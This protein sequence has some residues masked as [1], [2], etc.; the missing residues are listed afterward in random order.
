M[1]LISSLFMT[2]LFVSLCSSVAIAG[3]QGTT[4]SVENTASST[5]TQTDTYSW[6]VQKTLKPNQVPYIIREGQ[7]LNVDYLLTA[8]RSSPST[9]YTNT[10]T[11][12]SICV[13]NTG[14]QPTVGLWITVSLQ[15]SLDGGVSWTNF[16][17]PQALSVS[18]VAAGSTQCFPYSFSQTLL[19]PP[20]LYRNYDTVSVDNFVGSEG[21]TYSIIETDSVSVTPILVEI[22]K[23]ATLQ[24]VFTCPSG[25]SCTPLTSTMSLSTSYPTTPYQVSLTNNSAPCGQTLAGLNTATLTPSTNPALPSVSASATIYTGTCH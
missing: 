2:A 17:G 5:Q 25:F 8:T 22:D 12:G 15:Q 14:T 23:T 18:E 4:V 20:A 10:P 21:T 3:N 24:D 7:T 1:T 6:S 16:A 19:P 11:T 9:V 13:E